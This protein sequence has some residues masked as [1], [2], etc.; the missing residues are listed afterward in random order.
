MMSHPPPAPLRFMIYGCSHMVLWSPPLTCFYVIAACCP[1]IA[2]IMTLARGSIRSIGSCAMMLLVAGAWFKTVIM[3]T[4]TTMQ[5]QPAATQ[6]T[7]FP[8]DNRVLNDTTKANSFDNHTTTADEQNHNSNTTVP[9][10]NIQ[11]F[12]VLSPAHGQY[13]ER[14]YANANG[15]HNQFSDS[16]KYFTFDR[17]LPKSPL[18]DLIEPLDLFPFEHSA[19]H[20]NL[21]LAAFQR[22][23]T[24][25]NASDWY[26]LAEDD[27]VVVKE[28]LEEL[29]SRLNSSELV[30]KGKCVS[31]SPEVYFAMGG[32][33]ILMSNRMLREMHPM[34]NTCRERF[35]KR[36]GDV[37][38]GNCIK[39]YVKPAFL[40]EPANGAQAY[41]T[42]GF[43]GSAENVVN[44][45]N[46]DTLVVTMHEKSP[47]RL[48]RLNEIV[49]NTT[50]GNQTFTSGTLREYESFWRVD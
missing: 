50:R 32:A 27:T 49:M 23:F 26:F 45:W 41:C 48:R 1:N 47:E 46:N 42:P 12:V 37:R 34:M 14:F 36:Y 8:C 44:S 29:V 17:I 39:H 2:L 30:M 3:S 18:R 20:S 28:N 11:V 33:G 25:N 16:I 35:N 15:W 4:T 31:V 6:D 19:R 22:M 38:I 24:L 5:M 7:A 10:P 9:P 21:L 40:E 13:W 43:P